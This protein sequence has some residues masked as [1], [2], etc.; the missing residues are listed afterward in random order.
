MTRLARLDVSEYTNLANVARW[1]I[2][3]RWIAAAGVLLVLGAAAIAFQPALPLVALF[4]LAG[5]LVVL[6]LCFHLYFAVAKRGNLSKSELGVFFNVQI[7]T[8]YLLL[9]F[10]VYFTG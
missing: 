3:L 6:N 9:F 5:I 2:I 1:F 10:L 4:S 7:C 8:D